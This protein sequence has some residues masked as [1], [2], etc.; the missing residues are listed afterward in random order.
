MD[1][2]RRTISSEESMIGEALMRVSNT[3]EAQRLTKSL[4]YQEKLRTRSN[5]RLIIA[6]ICMCLAFMMLVVG[7]VLLF[8]L[9]KC[10][11]PI[12]DT[13]V[14][15]CKN[16][17]G[18]MDSMFAALVETTTYL[19]VLMSQMTQML[20]ILLGLMSALG[21]MDLAGML[22]YLESALGG[23]MGL[24]ED[25]PGMISNLDL[26][27]ILGSMG[28]DLDTVSTM[29]SDTIGSL[30]KVTGA[31]AQVTDATITEDNVAVITDLANDG[32]STVADATDA[33]NGLKDALTGLVG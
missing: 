3:L 8:V 17:F 31:M 22:G 15:F 4:D 21:S 23:F 28:I 9:V 33:I 12:L 14:P 29:V 24:L 7:G 20:D 13:L 11:D 19:P 27:D 25:V 6:I 5:I 26:G 1:D 18:G 32:M 10:Q 30:A 2:R 16:L